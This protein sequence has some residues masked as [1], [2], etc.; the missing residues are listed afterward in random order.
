MDTTINLSYKSWTIE[1]FMDGN[2]AKV[3]FV[4]TDGDLTEEEFFVLTQRISKAMAAL[5]TL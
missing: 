5:K 4:D 1:V 2:K 3:N